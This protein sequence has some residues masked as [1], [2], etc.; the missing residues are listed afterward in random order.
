MKVFKGH[1]MAINKHTGNLSRYD[2]KPIIA[3]TLE[4]A[5]SVAP[6]YVV[7]DGEITGEYPGFEQHVL[8]YFKNAP[9]H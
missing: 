7:I 9:V 3:E 6:P 4:E 1:F 5:E 2:Y 8:D